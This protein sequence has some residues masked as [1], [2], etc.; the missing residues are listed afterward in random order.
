[1]IDAFHIYAL[2]EFMPINRIKPSASL[3]DKEVVGVNSQNI[4]KYF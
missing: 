2:A 1:M 3:S 4:N